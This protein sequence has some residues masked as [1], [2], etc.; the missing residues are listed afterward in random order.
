MQFQIK[1]FTNNFSVHWW[2]RRVLPRLQSNHVHR[3]PVLL[4]LAAV[5]AA[6][7]ANLVAP[8][9][10]GAQRRQLFLVQGTLFL[11]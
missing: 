6:A 7:P 5:Q 2:P 10:F 3:V 8:A 4:R 1:L 11:V 9:S